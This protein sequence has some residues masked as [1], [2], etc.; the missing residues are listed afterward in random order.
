V[1]ESW[2]A[3]E[4]ILELGSLVCLRRAL[5]EQRSAWLQRIHAQLFHHRHPA[6]RD[7]LVRERRAWVEG[8]ELPHAARTQIEVA[9]SLI[10]QVNAQLAAS[11]DDP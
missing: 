1:P 10:D 7:L 3:P 4:H 6:R 9:L 5:V 2:I 11:R 8:L